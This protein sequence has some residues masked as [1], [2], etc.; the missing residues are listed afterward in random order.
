[1]GNCRAQILIRLTSTSDPPKA[2]PIDPAMESLVVVNPLQVPIYVRFG[3]DP[4]DMTVRGGWDVAAPG[5]GLYAIPLPVD[6][7][8]VSA[9]RGDYGSIDPSPDA[10][11]TALIMVDPAPCRVSVGPLA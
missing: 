10:L 6:A 5:Q 7:E 3:S 4:V 8:F 11:E 2:E 9:A 1:M